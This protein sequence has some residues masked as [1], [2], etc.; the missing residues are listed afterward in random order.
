MV[1]KKLDDIWLKAAVA[2]SLWACMEIVLGSFLHNLRLP[3][4][5]SLLAAIALVFL[6][7]MLRLWSETGLVWRAGLV[8]AAMKSLSPSA[9]LF[10]PMVA[11]MAEAFLFESGIRLFGRNRLGCLI[12]GCLAML[13]LPVQKVGRLL[14]F[15]G[16]DMLDLYVEMLVQIQ[17]RL[18]L[19]WLQT[20][21]FLLVVVLV[22]ITLASIAVAIGWRLG[23][24]LRELTPIPVEPGADDAKISAS[25]HKIH[26]SL[27]WLISHVLAIIVGLWLLS[28]TPFAYGTIFC[29]G[30]SAACLYRYRGAYRR[31]CKP[32]FWIAFVLITLLAGVF[33]GGLHDQQLNLKLA[34]IMI[35][36]QMNLRAV[37]LLVAFTAL[38]VELGNPV[39]KR[40]LQQRGMGQFS[41]A[42]EL[43]FRVMPHMLGS[44]MAQKLP[45]RSPLKALARVLRQTDS[46]LDTFRQQCRSE[47]VYLLVGDRGCGKTSMVQMLVAEL[48]LA[49]FIVGGLLAKGLWRNN[50]RYGFDLVDLQTKKSCPLC[51]TDADTMDVRNGPYG[52]FDQGL[53]FGHAAL[54]PGHLR[55]VDLVIVDEVGP[56]ELRGGG[57]AGSLHQ[58]VNE[59]KCPMIWTVRS[60]LSQKVTQA[61]GLDNV[62]YWDA[63][64]VDVAYLM[65]S[66][67]MKGELGVRRVTP[68]N[69]EYQYGD[70]C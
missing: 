33:L 11:I 52:F 39:I 55:G 62:D 28:S 2:G 60:R 67:D 3:F 13:W 68:T 61:W 31:F 43:A 29:L 18:S 56:L 17:Q 5:G 1:G 40:L 69:T 64:Q 12:A 24:Q 42:L 25:N 51:R 44:L 23:V 57:W 36:F 54:Q 48:E 45:L 50:R 4:A 15:Y 41:I 66:L 14:L 47:P 30:Y 49:G 38:G 8:C 7:A 63:T 35:G 46:W 26:W 22:Y 10:G 65:A 53:Q 37:L 70:S 27:R 20:Q 34:S 58:L 9:I 21:Q 16:S 19:E 32:G 59:L 6:V